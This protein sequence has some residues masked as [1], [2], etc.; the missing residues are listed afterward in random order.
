LPQSCCRHNTNTPYYII[1]IIIII[2]H[3]TTTTNTFYT[4]NR[5]LSNIKLNKG[6][7]DVL[8]TGLN[9][10]FESQPKRFIK[11]L[12][13]DTENAMQHLDSNLRNT[14]RFL[15][16][17]RITQIKTSNTINILHKRKIYVAKQIR[18]KLMQH[19]LMIAKADKGKAII[20]MDKNV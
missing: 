15:A 4:R 20:T 12:I 17:R 18:N 9:Y 19:N 3:N 14:Y 7:L 11:D 1:I 2:I 13:I 8:E 5:K 6:E 16:G 10:A